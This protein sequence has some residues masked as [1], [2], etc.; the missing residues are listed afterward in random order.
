MILGDWQRMP[1]LV[2]N[3]DL[4]QD[5]A[6]MQAAVA[7]CKAIVGGIL[8]S[9]GEARGVAPKVTTMRRFLDEIVDDW[10][11]NR[12]P[13]TLDYDDRFGEDMEIVSDLALKQVIGNV[14]DN[15]AEVSP[16]W[17]GVTAERADDMLLLSIADAG[18]GFAAEM[19]AAFGQ[20]YRSTKGRPGRRPWPVPAGQRAAHP[21][22]PGGGAQPAGGRRDGDD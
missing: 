7:R 2:R 20:P 17:I 8:T 6:D 16:E 13:S 1:A 15:A 18:P 22:R 10:R 3:P 21:R 4:A 14:I 12:L 19:L 11:G 9:A 5:I